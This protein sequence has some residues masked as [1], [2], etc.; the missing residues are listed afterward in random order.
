M[1][2]WRELVKK[3]RVDCGF[4][5]LAVEHK[6]FAIQHGEAVKMA[7]EQ[8]AL[9]VLRG[10]AGVETERK[11]DRRFAIGKAH[12]FNRVMFELQ[13]IPDD[14]AQKCQPVFVWIV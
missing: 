6:G 14:R 1:V 10:V 9:A 7:A 2:I 5:G 4:C 13:Q 8:N 11:L 3:R 12:S